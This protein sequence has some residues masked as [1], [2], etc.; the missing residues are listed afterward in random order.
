MTTI[1][2]LPPELLISILKNLDNLG[3]RISDR[4]GFEDH[5][6]CSSIVHN[7][8][9]SQ[10]V[11]SVSTFLSAADDLDLSIFHAARVS[12]VWMH[13]VLNVMYHRD[14]SSWTASELKHN[15]KT[16]YRVAVICARHNRDIARYKD[17]LGSG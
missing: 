4:F 10:K 6:T 17:L 12:H 13:I 1:N 16:M 5:V 8:V 15:E 14:P 11:Y 9:K 2:D 3:S 7:E